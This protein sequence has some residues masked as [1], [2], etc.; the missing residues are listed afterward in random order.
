MQ[1]GQKKFVEAETAAQMLGVVLPDGPLTA[2]LQEFLAEQTEY[3][4]I[5]ADQ[6][7]GMYRFCQEARPMP[8]SG[9]RLGSWSGC[10]TAMK[11]CDLPYSCFASSLAAVVCCCH[12]LQRHVVGS[13]IHAVSACGHRAS[14][15]NSE[16]LS[17]GSPCLF[18]Q[19]LTV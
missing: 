19:H 3:K 6:W 13:C 15:A 16:P 4:V 5:S 17:T 8:A 1:D 11:R 14:N 10:G 9:R 18:V 2:R 7:L 12:C